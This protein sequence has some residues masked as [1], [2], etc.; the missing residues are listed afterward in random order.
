MTAIE[1]G[2]LKSPERMVHSVCTAIIMGLRYTMTETLLWITPSLPILMSIFLRAMLK[3]IEGQ[4][5]SHRSK[6]DNEP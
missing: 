1:T 4:G 6:K 2:N 5:E 3:Q